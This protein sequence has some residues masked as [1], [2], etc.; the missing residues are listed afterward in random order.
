MTVRLADTWPKNP[1]P[2][3]RFEKMAAGVCCGFVF[4]DCTIR[5]AAPG[6]ERALFRRIR[7]SPRV[8]GK[9]AR[10]ARQMPRDGSS[11][12]FRVVDSHAWRGWIGRRPSPGKVSEV[13]AVNNNWI[14]DRLSPL[15]SCRDCRPSVINSVER[16]IA[17]ER[18]ATK[19]RSIS[20]D[21]LPKYNLPFGPW[22][23][24]RKKTFRKN[25]TLWRRSTGDCTL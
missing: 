11:G 22:P 23:L 21:L 18:R 25:A 8:A 13:I 3:L 6:N 1:S 14:L 24:S 19:G 15:M 2:S 5:G 12:G 7:F 20:V 16:H 9:F 4:Q 17:Q 10:S